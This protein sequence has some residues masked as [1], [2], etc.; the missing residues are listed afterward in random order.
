MLNLSTPSISKLMDETTIGRIVKMKFHSQ[1]PYHFPQSC[2]N[3]FTIT[4]HL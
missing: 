2:I 4:F 1:S 3:S